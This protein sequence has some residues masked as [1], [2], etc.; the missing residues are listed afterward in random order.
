MEV[1]AGLSERELAELENV[2]PNSLE[3][4]PD[5]MVL[6]DAMSDGEA[7]VTADAETYSVDIGVVVVLV[8]LSPNTKIT[9]PTSCAKT[10]VGD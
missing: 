9:L 6:L 8:L 7:V 5:A 2:V 1:E 3:D 4:I 10:T